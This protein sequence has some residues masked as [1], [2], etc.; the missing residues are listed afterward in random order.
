MISDFDFHGAHP[1][2]NLFESNV[3]IKF[4]PASPG[5]LEPTQPTQAE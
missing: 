2:M 4:R 5:V 1:T 3:G